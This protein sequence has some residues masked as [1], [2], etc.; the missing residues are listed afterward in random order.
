[1]LV[2]DELSKREPSDPAS[3]LS[4]YTVHAW[5]ER[6]DTAFG[7]RQY[8]RQSYFDHPDYELYDQQG[9]LNEHDLN[10]ESPVKRSGLINAIATGRNTIIV[11]AAQ[12]DSN[13]LEGFKPSDYSAGGPL[14]HTYNNVGA[15]K[16]SPD[17]IRSEPRNGV[18][19]LAV[20]D[21]SVIRDGIRAAGV[22]S[23]S[24]ASLNGSSVAAP[25]VTRLVA[26]HLSGRTF[27]DS[28]DSNY[29]DLFKKHLE[30][31]S[32][33]TPLTV[34]KDLSGSAQAVENWQSRV[35]FGV[36]DNRRITSIR[37]GSEVSTSVELS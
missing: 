12:V 20:S 4:P 17:I 15:G 34:P 21:D 14:P 1:M 6:D 29:L 13:N 35:G 5:I 24:I 19:L 11:G 37:Q 33:L 9:R 10:N 22:R 31:L 26:D 3:G 7:Y 23:G 36:V 2:D 16:T 25:Q 28:L 18:D 8:G 27:D 30:K 32:V